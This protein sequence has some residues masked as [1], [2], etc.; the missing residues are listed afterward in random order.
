M[1]RRPELKAK[2]PL[3]SS[4][5]HVSAIIFGRAGFTG[6]ALEIRLPESRLPAGLPASEREVATL[7]LAG[8][9]IEAIAKA[10]RRSRFTV[11][12]QV[13]SLYRRLHVRSRAELTHLLG[14]RAR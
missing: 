5:D 9:S 1:K 11:M 8:H 12:N 2:G 10:R 7:L 14:G 4:A 3:L 13:Q 6:A